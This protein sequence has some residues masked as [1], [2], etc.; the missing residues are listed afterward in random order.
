MTVP[1]GVEYDTNV[2]YGDDQDVQY[3]PETLDVF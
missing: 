3:V 2:G 1:V